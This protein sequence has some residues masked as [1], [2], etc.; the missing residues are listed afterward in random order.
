MEQVGVEKVFEGSYDP[1]IDIDCAAW[2]H[3]GGNA[4]VPLSSDQGH[5]PISPLSCCRLCYEHCAIHSLGFLQTAK[6]GVLAP[7]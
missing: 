3:T 4:T 1:H 5:R 2:M 7:R 6:T